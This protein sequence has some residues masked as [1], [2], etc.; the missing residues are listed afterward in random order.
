M[1]KTFLIVLLIFLSIFTFKNLFFT[2]FQQDEWH[3]FGVM[4]ADGLGYVTM[5]QSLA[6]LLF[7]GDR[8]GARLLMYLMFSGFGFNSVPFLALSLGLHFLN[9]FIVYKIAFKLLKDKKIAYVSL[10][11]FLFN[12]ISSQTYTWLG[13]FAGTVPN[14]TFLLLSLYVYLKFLFDKDKSLFV[15]LSLIL[16]WLSFLFKETGFFFL[17]LYPVAYFIYTKNILKTL[18]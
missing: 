5:N 6:Q 13:T 14:M 1:K 8:A 3:A 4:L 7:S 18:K 15:Y 2:Y 12:G 10:L 11:F 16:L 17:M 9:A